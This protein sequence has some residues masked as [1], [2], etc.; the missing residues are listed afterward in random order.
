MT[1][2]PRAILFLCVANSARSQMAEGLAR[3]MAPEGTKV[4]SAGSIPARV[5][6]YA[7]EVMGELGIDLSSHHSKSV[8]EIPKDEVG[9]VI[10]LCAE[11][12]CPVFPGKVEKLH[13]PQTDPAATVGS[14]E[15]ILNAF[16][17][18]RDQLRDRL[19]DF[20]DRRR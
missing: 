10:T 13:W 12:V 7:I 2:K 17:T 9:T 15:E 14:K 16:R 6:P 1:E 19:Q 8:D 3:S 11:E 18:V 4:L 20:F 5:S